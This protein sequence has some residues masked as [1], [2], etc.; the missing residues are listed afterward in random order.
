MLTPTQR[1]KLEIVIPDMIEMLE[2]EITEQQFNLASYRSD[3]KDGRLIVTDYFDSK[4]YGS[5]GCVFGWLVTKRKYR[6][7]PKDFGKNFDGTKTVLLFIRYIDRIIGDYFTTTDTYRDLFEQYGYT[8]SHE[9]VSK[10]TVIR[11]LKKYYN[12]KYTPKYI[13]SDYEDNLDV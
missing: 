3:V 1:Q 6:P 7:I 13:I 8:T 2:Q 5:A 10:D 11:K 9:K 12:D 4:N